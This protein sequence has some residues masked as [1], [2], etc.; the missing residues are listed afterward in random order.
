FKFVQ[1]ACFTNHSNCQL[2]NFR[3]GL[4]NQFLGVLLRISVGV[5]RVIAQL[6]A[7]DTIEGLRSLNQPSHL[8]L[9]LADPTEDGDRVVEFFSALQFGNSTRAVTRFSETNSLDR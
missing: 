4:S 8:K 1:L 9:T 2:S 6:F 5:G 3:P 7:D